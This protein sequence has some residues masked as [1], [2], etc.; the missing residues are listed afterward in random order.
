LQLGR[1]RQGIPARLLF[2][3]LDLAI[4]ARMKLGATSLKESCHANIQR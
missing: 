2:S 1:R 4:V 3:A